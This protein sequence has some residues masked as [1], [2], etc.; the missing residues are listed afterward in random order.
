M[1][2]YKF[3]DI[4]ELTG[5]SMKERH[6]IIEKWPLRLK[7]KP[8]QRGA[9]EEFKLLLASAHTGVERYVEWKRTA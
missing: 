3:R 1:R 2:R 6:T 8:H 7:K 4:E 9:Q 5:I